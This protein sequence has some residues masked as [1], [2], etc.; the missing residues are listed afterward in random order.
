MIIRDLD[1][2]VIPMGRI[3]RSIEENFFGAALPSWLTVTGNSTVNP[4]SNLMDMTASNGGLRLNA[5]T[6]TGTTTYL[7]MFP[8]GIKFDLFKEI[9]IDVTFNVWNVN[10]TFKFKML[11]AAETKG[12]FVEDSSNQLKVYPYHSVNGVGPAVNANYKVIASGENNKRRTLRFRLQSDGTFAIAV[13]DDM[14]FFIKKF[15]P[16]ELETNDILFP[17]V[18]HTI[19]N[20][21]TYTMQFYKVGATVIHNT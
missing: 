12:I 17:K 7:S 8:T 14:Y 20:A 3:S 4:T 5:G 9:I 1:G 16:A 10:S 11:N 15:T 21:G 2:K 13:E 19:R 6:N 18:G